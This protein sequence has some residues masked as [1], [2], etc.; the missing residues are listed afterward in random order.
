MKAF[1]ELLNKDKKC[2]IGLM[3][4]TSVDGI[5][6]AVV[7]ITGH[8]LEIE[9][10]LIAFETFHFPPGVPQ[11]ILAL[12]HPDTG[13]VDD[14]CEMN[15]Y[16]GHL[17]AEAVK[18]I[19]QKSGMS[20]NDIDLIGSHGQTIYHL[21]HQSPVTSYQSPVKRE[22]N[23]TIA[24]SGH[25]SLV[26]GN[27]NI[28]EPSTLQIGEPAVIAHETGIPTIADF[29]VAD[30]AAGGQGAPLVSYIDYLLFH[31]SVKTVGLLN[32]GG[33]ANLTV[34]P[35][36]GTF[37]SVCAA[38][39][40]PG[41]MCIDAV[42][43]E[44][45]EGA[46]HYDKDGTRAAAGT[47][48]QLLIGEWLK[49][50][51][52]HQSPPKTTGREMFGYTYAMECLAACHEHEL[53]DNDCIATLTEL[54]VQT[55]ADYI[56]KFVTE[57][58]PIDTLYVSGGGVHNQTIMH[59]LNELLSDTSVEPVDNSGISADAKEAI[60][61]AILANET[62]HGN[63]GNL[64]SATGASVRKVLGKFVYP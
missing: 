57:Q 59:R 40:G 1:I 45:T 4:G 26:T 51:F 32:I 28:K 5:D 54:T 11:R 24:F 36:N 62:L 33:I 13:R 38:D 16:I 6:A 42:V 39:T 17:F 56:A 44:I 19:L 43:S 37:D 27:R 46:E 31:N 58:N 49:H 10:E 63:A 61:F 29:R 53:S 41:N 47:A 20:A 55:I 3:S 22:E 14:I 60:A 8:G 18:C 7:E 12:C 48:H 2:V 9:V 64:P 21:P 30:M 15:F 52:F 23:P 50:P 35:A 34:L 25:W